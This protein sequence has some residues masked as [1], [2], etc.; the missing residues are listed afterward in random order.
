MIP[1]YDKWRWRDCDDG[2][3]DGIM[4]Y[5]TEATDIEPEVA[6]VQVQVRQVLVA[7]GDAHVLLFGWVVAVERNIVQL[8]WQERFVR[9]SLPVKDDCDDG[10]VDGKGYLK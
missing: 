1:V 3:G 10:D 6:V 2:D 7:V 4:G 8:H 5:G 9:I